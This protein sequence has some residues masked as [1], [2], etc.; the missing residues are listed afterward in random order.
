[1]SF[2]GYKIIQWIKLSILFCC[3]VIKLYLNFVYV[4]P[5]LYTIPMGFLLKPMKEQEKQ[6]LG[7]VHMYTETH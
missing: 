4:K 1:M 7:L 6:N 3:L 5:S 2:F